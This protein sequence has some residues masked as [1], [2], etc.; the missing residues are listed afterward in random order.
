M[1]RVN[2][3]DQNSPYQSDPL[4]M[5][6]ANAPISFNSTLPEEVKL[7]R[8]GKRARTFN[9]TLLC[10]A[11]SYK[12]GYPFWYEISLY[13]ENGGG[14]VVTVKMFTRSEDERDLF[15]VFNAPDFDSLVLLLES[16][17]P[18]HDLEAVNL[19]IDD[20]A[21]SSCEVALRGIALRLKIDEARR[22]YGD[23]A[24]EILYEIDA[25]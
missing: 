14:F 9:G 19:G 16:Y 6:V 13:R 18:A 24:G 8:T 15:H 17:D 23:I 5:G 2:L 3:Y 1:S 21:L 7:R 25:G 22:Q 4:D 12:P 20:T 10:T 11:M